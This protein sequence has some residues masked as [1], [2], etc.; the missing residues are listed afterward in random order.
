MHTTTRTIPALE[1]F[2]EQRTVLLT[3]FRRDGRPVGRP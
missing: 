1:R 3:S 2:V